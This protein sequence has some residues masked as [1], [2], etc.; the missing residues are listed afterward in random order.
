MKLAL[1]LL[2]AALCLPMVGCA[3][4]ST[5][6]IEGPTAEAHR[7]ERGPISRSIKVRPP[8]R[9]PK[10]YAPYWTPDEDGHGIAGRPVDPP[11]GDGFWDLAG[12]I[13]QRAQD[14][15]VEIT[16]E[17][18][19]ILDASGKADG[20]SVNTSADE[21]AQ[22][23]KLQAAPVD[24][25]P[26]GSKS[27][28]G[29]RQSSESSFDITGKVAAQPVA[30]MVIGALCLIGAALSF[31]FSKQ[32]SVGLAAAGGAILAFAFYPELG[33]FVLLG[34]MAVAVVAAIIAARK[35]GTQQ[36]ALASIVKGIEDISDKNN[37]ASLG[38][39]VKAALDAN[40]DATTLAKIDAAIDPI[41]S[42]V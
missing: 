32:L 37:P 14:S 22:N 16:E 8:S 2:S 39:Q 3:T 27:R 17:Y 25:A 15:E 12:A 23:A 42:K 41:K 33:V 26:M 1:L 40:L 5:S 21:V 18:G 29:S 31:K 6:K 7:Y 13:A 24:I 20:G 34:G 28:S 11:V 10:D 30:L 4:K 38:R 36:F 9:D 19:Q 35:G